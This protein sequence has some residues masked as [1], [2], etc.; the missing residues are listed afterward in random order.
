MTLSN[1]HLTDV[2]LLHHADAS[3]TCRYLCNDELDDSKW[4]CQKLRKEAKKI[5]DED[6][7]RMSEKHRHR[8]GIPSGDN[9][10]GYPLLKHIQ[11]GFDVD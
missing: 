10:K 6:L 3:L 8:S 9:C 4:Y 1:R 11:Q 7:S 2:C 5:V